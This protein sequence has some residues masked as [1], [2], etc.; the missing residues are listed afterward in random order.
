MTPLNNPIPFIYEGMNSG[1]YPWGNSLITNEYSNIFNKTNK[2][3]KALDSSGAVSKT[4]KIGVLAIGASTPKKIFSGI[5][6]AIDNDVSFADSKVTLVNAALPS[7]DFDYILDPDTDY[8]DSVDDEVDNAGLTNL[9]ISV[10]ICIEDNL[11]ISDTSFTRA[12]TLKENY[13]SLLELLRVDYPNCRLFLAGAREYT[14]YTTVTQHQEPRGYLNGWGIRLL[15]NDYVANLVPQYPLVGWLDY[16]W[17]DGATPRFDGLDYILSD[18]VG[19]D[20]LHLTKTKA[21]ELGQSTHDKLKESL[22]WYK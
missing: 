10:I 16:Y 9:Q 5:Q 11:S 14:G 2:R 22:I 18:Y 13:K 12:T 15:I 4:G 21:D 19:P 8:W 1:L 3:I 20:Y 6:T 17:A 7:K